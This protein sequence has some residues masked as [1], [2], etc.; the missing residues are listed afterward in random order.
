MVTKPSTLHEALTQGNV[1]GIGMSV[2]LLLQMDSLV[3]LTPLDV[4]TD[5]FYWYCYCNK[6]KVQM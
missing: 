2:E 3:V 1:S 6:V 4:V 5:I